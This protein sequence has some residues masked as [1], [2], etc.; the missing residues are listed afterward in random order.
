MRHI[1]P[2]S[3]SLLTAIIMSL[4]AACSKPAPVMPAPEVTVAPAIDREITDWDDFTGHFE[5]VQSVEVRPRVSG[6]IQRVS[7][8]EGANVQQG[9]VL[10]TIDARPYDAEVARA[11]AVLEQATTHEQLAHQELD[12][13]KQLVSTQAISREELDSRTSNLAEGGAAVRAAEAALRNAK[14][15]LDWTTVRAPISGRVGRAEITAGNLVQGGSP[16]AS[17]LTTIVSLD[18]IFVYFETDEQ[19]YLKYVGATGAAS[20]KSRPI[21]I[22]L[23]NETGFPHEGKLDFVDNRVDRTAG[24]MRIRAVLPNPNHLFAPGLFARVH[25]AGGAHRQVTMVQDQAIGTDQDRKFVLILKPDS[26]LEYRAIELGRVVDGLRVVQAGLKPGENV[27]INGLLRV[28]PGMKVA[29]KP[30][31]MLAIK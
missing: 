8:P 10:L 15:N 12:R 25:L 26:T 28:R 18:P 14:L 9:D 13:A 6:F 29:P 11:E 19:A 31:T 5:A 27:V 16:S 23:A 21:Q 7:F 20:G 22:G 4:A 17:L 24:T 30:G 1:A 2:R 3:T